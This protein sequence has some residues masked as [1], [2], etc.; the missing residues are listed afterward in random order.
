MLLHPHVG[1]YS[2]SVI[3]EILP[4]LQ[5]NHARQSFHFTQCASLCFAAILPDPC[6]SFFSFHNDFSIFYSYSYS[7]P[8]LTALYGY[9]QWWLTCSTF[10]R[11]PMACPPLSSPH[12]RSVEKAEQRTEDLVL[13]GK[14]WAT[15]TFF[16][17][18]PLTSFFERNE[19]ILHN[20]CDCLKGILACILQWF[21]L[22]RREQTTTQVSQVRNA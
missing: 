17:S 18:L 20:S 8:L 1:I 5:I 6:T 13:P 10:I 11:A 12:S 2:P 9:L 16:C 4:R 3:N 15:K 14:I 21:K 7:I 19:W 22:G